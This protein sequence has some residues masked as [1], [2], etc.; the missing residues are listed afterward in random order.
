M[1]EN[2]RIKKQRDG[3]YIIMDKNQKDVLKI[4]KKYFNLE[5]IE[6][7]RFSKKDEQRVYTVE[8]KK[9]IEDIMDKINFGKF[10]YDED[11]SEIEQD[12][13]VTIFNSSN[14]LTITLSKDDKN[15]VLDYNDKKFLVTVDEEF[16]DFIYDLYDKISS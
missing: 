12:I 1:I 6:K 14:L 9:L 10:V 2:N 3:Y 7:I 8:D 16:Y 5:K 4:D 13:T 15:A 11:I